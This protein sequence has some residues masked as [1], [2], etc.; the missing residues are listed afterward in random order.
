[1]WEHLV[2]VVLHNDQVD[3]IHLQPTYAALPKIANGILP[4]TDLIWTTP[5]VEQGWH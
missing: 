1:M 5:L 3:V 2:G 4:I